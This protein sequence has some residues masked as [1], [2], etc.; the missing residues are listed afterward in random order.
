MSVAALSQVLTLWTQAARHASSGNAAEAIKL[1]HTA[2]TI[3]HHQ[4]LSIAHVAMINCLVALRSG[5]YEAALRSSEQ[6]A[7]DAEVRAALLAVL[8][9]SAIST[10][11][12]AQTMRNILSRPPTSDYK[13]GLSRRYVAASVLVLLVLAAGG[14]WRWGNAGAIRTKSPTIASTTAGAS[15]PST[16]ASGQNP[17]SLNDQGMANRIGRV[18]V[19][20][21]VLDDRGRRQEVPVSSGTAFAVTAEGL[22][23]T[24]RHVTEGGREAKESYGPDSGIVGWHLLVAFGPSEDDWVP[25]TVLHTSQYRDVALLKVSRKFKEPFRFASASSVKQGDDLRVWGFPAPSRELGE[26]LNE[27]ETIARGRALKAK[28]GQGD[29]LQVSDWVTATEFDLITTRGIVSA[30]RQ[31]ESGSVIQTDAT[32]HPGNSGGPLLDGRGNVL[33]IVTAKHRDA[34]GTA[35]ALTWDAIAEDLERFPEIRRP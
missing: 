27:E 17:V 12:A 16:R 3:D 19:V 7:A 34:T 30:I 22:M 28:I 25:A 31:T 24:N 2:R 20:L 10:L 32:V 15:G 11:P 1:L 26:S 5:E 35:I 21:L 18:I 13:L 33:G 14:Y 23:L 4:E 29:R 8:G 6:C 9:S